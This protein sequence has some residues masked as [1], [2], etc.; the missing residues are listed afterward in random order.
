MNAIRSDEGEDQP[1]PEPEPEPPEDLPQT[2]IVVADRRGPPE[3]RQRNEVRFGE[4]QSPLP[5]SPTWV[6]RCLQSDLPCDSPWGPLLRA[7]DAFFEPERPGG[8]PW[9]AL[10]DLARVRRGYTTNDNAFFYPPEEAGIEEQWTVPLLKGARG[11]GGLGMGI[12]S[13]IFIHI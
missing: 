7:P 4:L 8:L 3:A 5:A 1:E 6:R 2:V 11:A 9:V 12:V 13:S 10:G